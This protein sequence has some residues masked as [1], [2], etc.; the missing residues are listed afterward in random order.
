MG[1][2]KDKGYSGRVYSE[3][4]VGFSDVGGSE[5]RRVTVRVQHRS[6]P[7]K[8]KKE[9]HA[10]ASMRYVSVYIYSKALRLHYLVLYS[11]RDIPRNYR[12][13]CR[14]VFDPAIA[15]PPNYFFTPCSLDHFM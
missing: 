6:S 12:W 9:V 13:P 11:H 14:C 5:R 4:Q 2:Y 15:G 8:I 7:Q 1:R 3:L 10:G